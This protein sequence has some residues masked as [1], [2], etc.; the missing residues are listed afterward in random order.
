MDSLGED[1]VLLSIRPDKGQL[2]TIQRI[3]FGLMGSELVRLAAGGR[4]DIQGDRVLVRYQKPTGDAELDAALG[5]LIEARRPPRPKIWVGHPRRGIQ[6]AYLNRLV[7]AGVLRAEPGRFFGTRYFIADQARAT[8]ARARLDAIALGT[9][10]V[11]T[12]QAAYG[13]LAHA[14]GLDRM[15]YSGRGARAVRKRLAEIGKG[16]WTVAAVAGAAADAAGEAI[17]ASVDA[18]A[19]AATRAATHATTHAAIHAAT[20]AATDAAIQAATQAA[21]QAATQA[22][23]QAA[24]EAAHHAGGGDAGAA[25]H[26][27]HH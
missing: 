22:A 2:A 5:S 9:G 15:L 11:D 8:D 26:G 10:P 25:G 16:Q 27:G 19:D 20:Q 13:G 21:I 1:L 14:I 23:T 18:A 24:V 4:I 12:A 3:D 17:Q 7:A 6:L